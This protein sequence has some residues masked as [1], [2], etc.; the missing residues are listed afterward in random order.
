M[1]DEWIDVTVRSDV[2]AA[3]LLGL[4]ADPFV[5]GSWQEGGTIHMAVSS[6]KCNG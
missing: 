3:E 1:P 5:Q 2:D 6:S 4:L